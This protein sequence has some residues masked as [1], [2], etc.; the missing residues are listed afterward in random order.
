[1]QTL[2]PT[3]GRNLCQNQYKAP[4]QYL[5]SL[6]RPSDQVLWS[7]SPI[8]PSLFGML[9]PPVAPNAVGCICIGQMQH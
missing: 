6:S 1:M 7:T 4:W 9:I 5:N 8:Q 2:C 3:G